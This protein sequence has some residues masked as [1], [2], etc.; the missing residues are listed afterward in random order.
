M[1]RSRSA[2]RRALPARAARGALLAEAVPV[3]RSIQAGLASEVANC[4]A[5]DCDSGDCD[6]GDEG[7]RRAR[8]IGGAL[9]VGSRPNAWGAHRGYEAPSRSVSGG[10]PADAPQAGSP[11]CDWDCG[12]DCD[13]NCEYI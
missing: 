6:D 4:H 13:C 12:W 5:H 10:L 9:G 8:A 2:G 7:K 3:A 11:V 1:G